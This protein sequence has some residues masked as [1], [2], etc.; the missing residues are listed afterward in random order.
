MQI[1][2]VIWHYN[3]RKCNVLEWQTFDDLQ[4]CLVP[5][6]RGRSQVS[7]WD[8]C[9]AS[10]DRLSP[11]SFEN[12]ASPVPWCC[13][14]I[15]LTGRSCVSCASRRIVLLLDRSD[16]FPPLVVEASPS[17]LVLTAV[18]KKKNRINYFCRQTFLMLWFIVQIVHEIKG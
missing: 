2:W 13:V 17:R 7:R 5:L 8:H 16:D 15:R 12:S 9:V 18:D 6:V 11:M 10:F 1:H 14:W 4:G 3:L